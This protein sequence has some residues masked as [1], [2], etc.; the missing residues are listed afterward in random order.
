VYR[1]IVEGVDPMEA[2]HRLMTREPK[3]E[4]PDILLVGEGS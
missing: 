3:S 4:N 1:I 2:L